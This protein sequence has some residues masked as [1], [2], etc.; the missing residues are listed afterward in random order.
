MKINNLL[1]LFL[2][3]TFIIFSCHSPKEITD[4][5]TPLVDSTFITDIPQK[6]WI[7]KTVTYRNGT[8]S[9]QIKTVLCHKIEEERSLQIIN[10][11][12]DDKLLVSFDDLDADIKDYYYTIIHCNSNWTASDLMQ[13]EYIDGFTD[14][15]ISDYEFSFNTIQKYTHYQFEFPSTNIKP[16]LSGNYIFKI[17]EE[18]KWRI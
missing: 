4:S 5:K 11:N 13:S 12:S 17:Y 10:L 16:I 6:I 8:F 18:I 3:G 1:T 7:G 9:S 15:P 14:E 2:L